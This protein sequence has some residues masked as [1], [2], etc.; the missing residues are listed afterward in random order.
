LGIINLP[1]DFT[2][3]DKSNAKGGFLELFV[4]FKYYSGCGKP[5]KSVNP[6]NF[7]K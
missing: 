3:T 7:I 2:L 1:L 6:P 5:V 4:F